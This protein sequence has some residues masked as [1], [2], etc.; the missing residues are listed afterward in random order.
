MDVG[1]D[2]RY[3]YRSI[4][5][6]YRDWSPFLGSLQHEDRLSFVRSDSGLPINYDI[7]HKARWQLFVRIYI[8]W[9]DFVQCAGRS[10]TVTLGQGRRPYWYARA[11]FVRSGPGINGLRLNVE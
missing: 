1:V 8:V 7:S 6:R 9:F 5:L 2:I 3:R 11:F 4:C 10:P